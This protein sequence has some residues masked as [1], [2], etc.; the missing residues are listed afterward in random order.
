MPTSS[1]PDASLRAR[2]IVVRAVLF[3]LF[4]GVLSAIVLQARQPA[5]PSPPYGP[6]VLLKVDGGLLRLTPC[7][8]SIVRVQFAKDAAF[9]AKGT[10]ATAPRQCGGAAWST[11]S[12]AAETR[13]ET[14]ALVLRVDNTTGRVRVFDRKGAPIV[15]ESGRTIEPARLQGETTAHVRQAWEAQDES[16]H[17][18]GQHQLGLGDIKGYDLDLWQHNATVAIPFLV[19]SR[20]YGIL[21]ENTSFTRFGD[22][23]APVNIPAS[24]LY[25]ATGKAG[26]FTGTY[27]A[28]ADFSK[29]VATRVDAAIDIEIPGGTPTPNRKIHPDLPEKGDASVRWEGEVRADQTGDHLFTT[30]SNAGI[31]LSVDGTVLIDHWRQGWL[32][33]F[34]VARVPMKAGARYKLKLEWRKDQGVETMQ[35]RWKTPAPSADTSLWSEVGDGIDYYLV[36][37]PSIDQVIAGYRRLTGQAPMMPRWAFGLWQC[38]ERYKTAQESLDVVKEFRARGIPLDAIVQDWQY[39]P[40]DSWGSHAFDAS[41]FPDPGGWVKALHAEHARLMISV[42]GKF[43][44]TTDNAKALRAK[45]WL[46]EPPLQEGLK[47][48]LGFPYTFY[49]AFSPGARQLFWDQVNTAVF[50]KGVDAW[51]MDATEPDI[52]QPM[53][54]LARQHELM[55]PTAA[56]TAS[57]VLNAYSLVNS[58]AVYE[59]QRAAAPNQRVFIL[60]RS[61]FSGQ[62]RYATATWSG[63]VTAT[64]TAFRQQIP[65][66]LGFSIS[67]LPYWTTDSGGFAVPPRWATDAMTDADREEWRELQA[68]WFEFAT[69]CPLT[70]I[71]GQYPFREPWNVAPAGH[72]AYETIVRYDRLRYRLLPYVYSLAGA[73]THDAGT[74]YRPLVMDYPSDARARQTTDAFLFGPALLVTPVTSYQARTRQVYLP[75]GTWYDLWTGAAIEGGRTIES[76]APF[77]RIPVHVRAG[78]IV[79]LGPELQYTGE[80]AA[81]PIALRVYAGANG[82]FTLYEDDGQTNEYEKGRFSRI[83][84][85]W[86]EASGTLTIGARVGEFDGMASRRTFNVV[87]VTTA[88]A[89]G[90]DDQAAGRSIAYEGREIVVRVR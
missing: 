57:R 89:A 42:W 66:G 63:D 82:R 9:F 64:W 39:W 46:Y 28:G 49:D 36:Y 83:P 18:L 44:P 69:F 53:P 77:D 79:P 32:P 78:S 45:G 8:D 56:G 20:G 60:T 47:D 80:R 75:K 37:G 7:T 70:R 87:V 1:C 2:T 62:Q 84:I 24:Q 30:Y 88:N 11:T 23:R 10:V 25:D 73:V 33:W 48:W 4:C 15:S 3:L 59:G 74:M 27:F 55:H 13:I 86:N 76:A 67:G 81:D 16:L 85:A 61:G 14:A 43:Y 40:L 5:P 68:R 31:R 72:P 52:A 34:D 26:G 41:R 17:G 54:T 12:T 35:L 19:S 38:R 65:A 22:L 21:W 71:H 51:W 29:P 6:E 50:S 90:I 58:Q